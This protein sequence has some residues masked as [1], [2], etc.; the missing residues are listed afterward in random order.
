MDKK[1]F[2]I[3]LVSLVEMG[4]MNAAIDNKTNKLN[5]EKGEHLFDLKYQFN[6]SVS[7]KLKRIRVIFIC[8]LNTFEKDNTTPLEITAHFEV[9]FFFSIE[10]YEEMIKENNTPNFDLG[11]ALANIVYSTSRGIIFTRCQ[12]TILKNWI[13]PILSTEQL[14]KIHSEATVS[15]K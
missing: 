14:R 15:R 1:I 13:L 6:F 12:G 2:N 11:V 9:A 7:E 8:D 3:N 5:L 10:N 4:I